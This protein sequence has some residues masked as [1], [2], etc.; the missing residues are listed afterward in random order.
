MRPLPDQQRL[1]GVRW[2]RGGKFHLAPEPHGLPVCGHRFAQ[3][4]DGRGDSTLAPEHVPQ[5]REGGWVCARCLTA[6]DRVSSNP[7]AQP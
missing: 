4:P 3:T 7:P 1:H 6:A 5:A 2:G